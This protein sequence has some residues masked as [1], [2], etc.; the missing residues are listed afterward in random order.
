MSQWE[1]RAVRMA[2]IRKVYAIL[3]VMLL[4]MTGLIAA[5]LFVP[6]IKNYVQTSSWCVK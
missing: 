5:M 4:T 1:D 2:F 3:T 6:E